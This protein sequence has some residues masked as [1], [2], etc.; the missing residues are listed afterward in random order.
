MAWISGLADKAE[1]MLVKLDQ[2]AASALQINSTPDVSDSS[3]SNALDSIR[4][5]LSTSKLS[6]KAALSPAKVKN[7][8]YANAINIRNESKE[9]LGTTANATLSASEV[10][11][12]NLEWNRSALSS[13]RSSVN[14]RTE[15]AIDVEDSKPRVNKLK[16]T[17]TEESFPFI[18][19]DSQELKAFKIALHEVTSER[20]DLRARLTI[21][22]RDDEKAALLKNLHELETL[23][24]RSTDERDQVQLELSNIRSTNAT[25]M[26]TISELEANLAKLQQEYMETAH[27]LQMQIKE[28]EIQ[29]KELRDYRVKAQLA[30]Q[31]KDN[32]IIELKSN[33]KLNENAPSVASD[34][35]LL[36]MEFDG[37]KEEHKQILEERNVLR[38]QLEEL[39]SDWQSINEQ[40]A[41][42]LADTRIVEE[43]IR[44]ELR[45]ERQRLVSS[46]SEQ[47]VQA[48]EL[49]KLRQQLSNQ[50]AASATH[51]QEKE[52]QLQK[53]RAEL[54]QRKTKAKSE[55]DVLSD[56]LDERIRVLTQTLVDKQQ[57]VEKITTE[58]N[59][60]RFQ[61]EKIQDQ[62]QQQYAFKNGINSSKQVSRNALLSNTTDDVK[63][64]FPLLMRENPFDNRVARRVKRAYSSL[65]SVGIRLGVF[66]RRYPLMR[67]FVLLYVGL[68]HLWVVFVL[69]S[70]SP[71]S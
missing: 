49:I 12:E 25:Y 2:N 52:A 39:R 46:E 45:T 42:H 67:I 44:K 11:H 56:N 22:C 30:L 8:N 27:K 6:L 37:L 34:L 21:M 36:Q 60:L 58:R 68:L 61:L 4:R 18:S 43:E 35:K 5:S 33:S 32:L 62:L 23:L 51:L 40:Y 47:R 66:L 64:Q 10:S 13:R 17:E 29:R 19:V 7:T 63:A 20:D 28:T 16:K 65:D 57:T 69:I 55:N 31:M 48:Q 14:S 71:N 38:I 24:Q 70:S 50:M 3:E 53:L 9:E 1:N 54:M 15:V 59:A 26:H 41:R